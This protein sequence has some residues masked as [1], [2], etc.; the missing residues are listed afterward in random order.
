MS[1]DPAQ[2]LRESAEQV[3]A[4]IEQ[5]GITEPDVASELRQNGWQGC[6]IQF[7]TGG[8]LRSGGL[9]RLGLNPDT[10]IVRVR[11]AVMA[12]RIIGAIGRW[13]DA[14]AASAK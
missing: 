2:R 7:E 4:L 11:D 6:L 13:D 1:N 9:L 8:A 5:L 14:W 12:Q 3:E 10:P